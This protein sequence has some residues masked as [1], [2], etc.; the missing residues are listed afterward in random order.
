MPPGPG[1]AAPPL[2]S[3]G[4]LPLGPEV[5]PCDQRLEKRLRDRACPYRAWA[6]GREEPAPGGRGGAV[7]ISS[8]PTRG[9]AGSGRPRAAK[10]QAQSSWLRL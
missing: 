3:Q 10:P 7:Y 5:R 4:L 6:A 8:G 2:K 9:R 1:P